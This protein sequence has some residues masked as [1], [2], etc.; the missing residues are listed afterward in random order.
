MTTL[1]GAAAAAVVAVFS[2]GGC[3]LWGGSSSESDA[4]GATA[5]T[6]EVVMEPSQKPTTAS[7]ETPVPSPTETAG[8]A[9]VGGAETWPEWSLP[10]SCAVLA[11]EVDE[12]GRQV[13][14]M[15]LAIDF[16]TDPTDPP[17]FGNITDGIPPELAQEYES[18]DIEP[19]PDAEYVG[20]ECEWW[21]TEDNGF[22]PS[23]AISVG[24]HPPDDAYFESQTEY[25]YEPVGGFDVPALGFQGYVGYGSLWLDTPRATILVGRDMLSVNEDLERALAEALAEYAS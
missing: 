7:P 12:L 3:S 10:T 19:F 11:A 17:E 16:F 18:F 22:Y 1:V 25:G 2:L 20:L 24:L 13:E 8:G 4:S 5:K 9:A 6:E 15:P 23:S 21:G 14:G